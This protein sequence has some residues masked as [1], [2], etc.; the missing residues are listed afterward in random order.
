MDNDILLIN[1]LNFTADLKPK[2]D[3]YAIQL[4]QLK[5]DLH[6]RFLNTCERACL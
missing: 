4:E 3:D 1:L 6:V 5:S 2:K